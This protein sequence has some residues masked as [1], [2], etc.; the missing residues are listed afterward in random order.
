MEEWKTYRLG[1]VCTELSDGLHKAPIFSVNGEYIFVNAKNLSN[2]WIVDNDSERKTTF[3]EYLKYQVPLNEYSILYSI[4]GTIGNIAKYR[5]EKCILG[6]GACYI[7]PDPLIINRDYLY[8]ILQSTHFRKYIDNMATGSTIQHISL[9]TMRDY[10]FMAPSIEQ[11]KKIAS[12][13]TSIDNKI[14]TNNRI[15]HNLEEQAQALYKSWFV[16]FEPFKDGKFIESELGMIPEGWSIRKAEEFCEINIG[17]TPPRKEHQWF[18]NEGSDVTWISISDMGA[19]GMYIS[20]SSEMLTK[21]ACKK[22]N[23][24][25]VPEGTVLLSFK[26]TV[27]RVSIASK[28]LT[29]NEAIAR[30]L[31]PSDAMRFYLYLALKLYDYSK[32]GST[33]SIATAVNSKI[34]K[35]MPLTCPP[36]DVLKRFGEQVKGMFNSIKTLQEEIS[37]LC[38]QRDSLLQRLMSGELTC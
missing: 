12:V 14:D 3:E 28:D 2:G 16:D 7:N 37:C 17:K 23:I 15:N 38:E 34:I 8:Y 29:S 6:K 24:I 4:D 36:T 1:D 30:F 11:Q 35:G 26:L 25:V 21:E 5:G 32:L 31:A 19:S 27:G 22:F 9:H 33:S 10:V 13:L 20:R 18:S